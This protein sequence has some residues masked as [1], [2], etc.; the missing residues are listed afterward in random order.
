MFEG[1]DPFPLDFEADPAELSF[2]VVQSKVLVEAAQH[3]RQMVLLFVS[4]PMSVRKQP[5]LRSGEE[6]SA[7]FDA[8]QSDQGEAPSPINPTDM[9]E[10]QK[11]ESFRSSSM[12]APR[13]RGKAP[14][15]KQ[16]SFVLGQLKVEL[17]KSFPQLVLEVLR[18]FLKLKASYK[19]ISE[20]HQVRL[21]LA[22]RFDFPFKPQ[23]ER[24]VQVKIA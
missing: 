12:L 10:T 16:P 2:A 17:C 22:L 4:L 11:L 3:H 24:K 13:R 18:V 6:F 19:V 5:L 15:E 14:K 8:G 7:T 21:A 1:V 9:F 20:P 23:V